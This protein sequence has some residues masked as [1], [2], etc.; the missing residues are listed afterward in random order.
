MG[1][2][3][4]ELTNQIYKSSN[5]V[6]DVRIDKENNTNELTNVAEQKNGK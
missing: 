4:K 2:A 5:Q 3:V 6:Q 1:K